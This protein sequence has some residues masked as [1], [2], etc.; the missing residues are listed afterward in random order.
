LERI[1]GKNVEK[2]RTQADIAAEVSNMGPFSAVAGFAP[3]SNPTFGLAESLFLYRLKDLH[4]VT[5]YTWSYSHLV[6]PVVCF[7]SGHT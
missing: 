1:R 7:E 4:V 3:A 6:T 2:H 5:T